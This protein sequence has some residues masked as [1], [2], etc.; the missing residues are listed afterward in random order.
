[1]DSCDYRILHI[2]DL[3][4]GA[5]HFFRTALS[6]PGRL[7][8]GDSL[9]ALDLAAL[10]AV[11]ISG[12]LLDVNAAADVAKAKL[13]LKSMLAKIGVDKDRVFFVPG[14]HDLTWDPDYGSKPLHFY[15]D[16]LVDLGFSGQSGELPMVKVLEAKAGTKPLA[17]ILMN[18]CLVEGQTT[19]GLGRISTPQLLRI[20]KLLKGQSVNSK[21]HHIVAVLHHHLLPI[22]VEEIL[23]PNNP[24]RA[25]VK[26]PSLTVD[27]VEVLQKL[28][29]WGATAV[30][31]GHQHEPA[32][33]TYRN[34]LHSKRHVHVLAAGSCGSKDPRHFFVHE[35]NRS[36]LAVTS[37]R[38]SSKPDKSLFEAGET[39]KLDYPVEAVSDMCQIGIATTNELLAKKVST[40]TED[41]D[42]SDLFYVFMTAVDCAK[43]RAQVRKFVKSYKPGKPLG[44]YVHLL[45]MYDLMGRW[46]LAVRL[47]IGPDAKQGTRFISALKA[48]LD[49]HGVFYGNIN[50]LFHSFNI[51]DEHVSLK[52]TSRA[53]ERDRHVRPG[54]TTDYENNRLQKGFI[55]IQPG[56]QRQTGDL[57]ESLGTV[58]GQSTEIIRAVCE[59]VDAVII[60]LFM[61]C[62]QADYVNKLNREIGKPVA[63]LGG[64]KYSLLCYEYD[65]ELLENGVRPG[66]GS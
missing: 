28:T 41:D 7:S 43:A 20:E 30:L 18:S 32:I 45:G 59:A 33:L 9:E 39:T 53:R 26:L 57:L 16:L 6:D 52:K 51:T 54:G 15:D 5:S 49:E 13:E 8:L 62:P 19:A 60:E 65:E 4:F 24:K 27:A 23:D 29:E 66:S 50:H 22:C 31:H 47:R 25:L 34:H 11:V 46:D 3:H 35:F 17:L 61:T 64:Q 55:V 58:K 38:Q 12:D 42:N 10:D 1:M 63:N 48:H 40:A 21:S 44:F 37:Y 14:N 56:Q 36:S 2:S